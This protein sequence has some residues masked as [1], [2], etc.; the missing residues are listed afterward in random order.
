VD[1]AVQTALSTELNGD[2]GNVLK[3]YDDKTGKPIGPGS[4]LVGYP[5][6]GRGRNLTTRG[7]T[8]S[9]SDMME[10]TDIAQLEEDL[11]PLLPWLPALSTGRQVAVYSLYFNTGEGNPQ[12][13]IG[14]HG[15]PT[16]LA[17]MASGQFAAAAQN[18][19]TSQPWATE[20]GPRSGRLANLVQYG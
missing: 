19:R 14:P 2:E 1:A 3:V 13:F 15:W 5:T 18:L 12:K 7:I 10:T 17:Q 20:V 6:I 8:A 9:E 4:T 16:F 11:V